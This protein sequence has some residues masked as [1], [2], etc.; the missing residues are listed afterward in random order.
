MN[1]GLPRKDFVYISKI[2]DYYIF[3]EDEKIEFIEFQSKIVDC[4]TACMLYLS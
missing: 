4:E 2:I 1:I 3:L